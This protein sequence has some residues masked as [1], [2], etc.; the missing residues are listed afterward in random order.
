[1]VFPEQLS[2]WVSLNSAEATLDTNKERP[3]SDGSPIIRG[4]HS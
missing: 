4:A 3:Q 2:T 1:V